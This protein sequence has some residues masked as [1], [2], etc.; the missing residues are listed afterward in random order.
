M[1]QYI[2]GKKA[3]QEIVEN[4]IQYHYFYSI[5]ENARFANELLIPQNKIKIVDK[6]FFN[7]NR[8][9]GINHQNIAI[10]IDEPKS[11]KYEQ[12]IQEYKDAKN[13][14][15]LILDSIEDVGNFGSILR[16]A[17]AANVDAVFIRD[18]NQ[19]E[20]NEA[21]TKISMGATHL[22]KICKVTNLNNLIMNLKKLNFWVIGTDLQTNKNYDQVDYNGNIAI[23]MGSESDGIS[24]LV[25]KNCDEL[26]K[27]NMSSKIQSLNVG[28]ATG[29][30]LFHILKERN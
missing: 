3:V 21:V 13:L 23:V 28:V 11:W 25:K 8:F 4:R 2:C 17:C 5:K 12:I 20:I 9:K 30:I 15:F 14:T 7:T 26:V 24:E 16:T 19:V 1:K 22:I 18:K 27:I 10:E 6:D 29:I